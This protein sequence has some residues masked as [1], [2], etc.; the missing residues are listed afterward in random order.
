MRSWNQR[1]A[2]R[3]RLAIEVNRHNKEVLFAALTAANIHSVT[4]D[5]DGCGDDGQI[6]EI[7]AFGEGGDKMELPTIT[8]P[9]TI[10]TIDAELDEIKVENHTS[11]TLADAIDTLCYDF[12]EQTHDG[13]EISCDNF[14][15]SYG[16][17]TFDVAKK[18]IKLDFNERIEDVREHRH[19][20]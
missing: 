10:H 8:S 12:L 5:F 9:L 20:F 4:V 19:E 14:N 1:R 17:F 2:R 15:G 16:T 3:E 18:S 13:W 11:E 7:E 6:E